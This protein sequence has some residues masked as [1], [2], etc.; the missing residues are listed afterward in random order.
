MNVDKIGEGR[1][2]AEGRV[3][4]IEMSATQGNANSINEAVRAFEAV[5]TCIHHHMIHI[6]SFRRLE[7]LIRLSIIF[8]LLIHWCMINWCCFW[9]G[10]R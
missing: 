1:R 6:V 5:S 8:M 3:R 4:Q 2:G 7:A 10:A 9:G